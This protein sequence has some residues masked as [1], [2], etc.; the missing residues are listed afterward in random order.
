MAQ[1]FK[2]KKYFIDKG[3]QGRFIAGFAI[4]S[5]L[6][7]FLS[8]FVFRYLAWQRIEDMLYSMRLPDSSMAHLF[9]REMCLS[10]AVGVLFVLV[11][12]WWTAGKIFVRIHGPLQNL[13][14]SVRRIAGG[15]LERK[16]IL[17]EKDEFKGFA[18]ELNDMR[19]VTRK[20]LVRIRGHAD[21]IVELQSKGEEGAP[22]LSRRLEE[23]LAGLE[24]EV[25]AFKV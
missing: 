23:Y 22:D 13:V 20:R 2:R 8:V 19:E 12:F 25:K 1:Q 14:G 11:L 4:V 24:E 21:A 7:A 15:D 5:V 17:R 6:G 18:D 3:V 9:T 10:G 16:V